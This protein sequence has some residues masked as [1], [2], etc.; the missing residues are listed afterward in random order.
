MELSL[1]PPRGGKASACRRNSIAFAMLSIN[2]QLMPQWSFRKILTGL[3]Q[4]GLSYL[5]L[6]ETSVISI[7]RCSVFRASSFFCKRMSKLNHQMIFI[8]FKSG[9]AKRYEVMHLLVVAYT[10]RRS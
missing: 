3:L 9:E 10:W 1:T 4:S 7:L 8:W 5:K 2:L 6:Q